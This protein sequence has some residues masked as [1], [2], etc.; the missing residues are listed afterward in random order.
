MQQLPG[1]T[2]NGVI[3]DNNYIDSSNSFGPFYTPTG[4]NITFSGNVDMTSAA[5]IASPAG[6]MASDVSSVTVSPA[7][8]TAAA[9]S[10]ITISLNMDEV[11][12]VGGTPTLSLN[13][14]GTATYQTGSGTNVLTF[15]YAVG[16]SDT[17]IASL[18]VNGVN[19]P[20]GAR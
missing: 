6:T 3:V 12:S 5:Q 9:G 19:L 1:N 10:T 14:G 8:G 4:S 20:A 13:N 7:G 15:T 16:S 17:P 2:I 11:V 18:A